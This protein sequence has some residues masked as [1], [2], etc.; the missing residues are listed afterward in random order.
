MEAAA[1]AISLKRLR[2]ALIVQRDSFS[3]S[4]FLIF[5][6]ITSFSEF[7]VLSPT[8]RVRYLTA[9]MLELREAKDLILEAKVEPLRGRREDEF[10]SDLIS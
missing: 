7:V 9:C 1:L 2:N 10:Y 4:L 3:Q 5:N 6:K 8:L